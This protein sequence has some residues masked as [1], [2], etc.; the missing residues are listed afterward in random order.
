MKGY[1]L[2][3]TLLLPQVIGEEWGIKGSWT[4][5]CN[6][7]L[8]LYEGQETDWFETKDDA[9][10]YVE[11]TGITGRTYLLLFREGVGETIW[12][13]AKL[14]IVYRIENRTQMSL[15]GLPDYFDK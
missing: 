8:R 3:I 14:D 13:K 2:F 6:Y 9:T 7:L 12:L 11:K 4:P 5:E 15:R 10:Y 1:I